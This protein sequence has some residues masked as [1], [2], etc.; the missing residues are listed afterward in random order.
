MYRAAIVCLGLSLILGCAD[1]G[2][3]RGEVSGRVTV[4]GKPVPNATVSFFP[5]SANGTPSY[6]ATDSDGRYTLMFTRSKS[7][8][9]TGK[10]RVEI[11]TQKISASEAAEMKAEGQQV[12]T[13]YIAIPP[14][15]AE[16]GALTANVEGGRNEINFELTTQ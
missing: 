14:K 3:E 16:P 11:V 5:E 9:M 4:D 6:G 7:G 15:Y 13:T 8:A 10:S 2:P 1:G 12:D